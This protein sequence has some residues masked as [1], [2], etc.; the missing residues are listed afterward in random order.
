MLVSTLTFTIGFML[1]MAWAVENKITFGSFC[2]LQAALKQFGNVSTALWVCVI[3]V[4]TFA[5]VFLEIKVPN[6]VFYIVFCMV[7]LLS[8]AII[9]V[10]PM[11]Y[12]TE[13]LGPWYGISAQWCWTSDTYA[14]PRF[15]TEYLWVRCLHFCAP[16]ILT[17]APRCS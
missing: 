17:R 13:Q 11:F 2:T 10:G 5:A 6:F 14:S 9:A 4:H 7:W 1:S 16:T 12:T 8:G 15:A 3:A